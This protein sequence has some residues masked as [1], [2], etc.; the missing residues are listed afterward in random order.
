[1]ATCF[2]VRQLHTPIAAHF[3]S[4]ATQ[5][6]SNEFAHLE[7]LRQFS[8]ELF[9]TN[10]NSPTLGFLLQSAGY[11]VCGP[12]GIGDDGEIDV[13]ECK[14]AFMRQHAHYKQMRPRYFF[15]VHSPKLFPGFADV[16]P[17]GTLAGQDRGGTKA[18]ERMRTNLES[19]YEC[20]FKNDLF[21]VYDLHKPKEGE[22]PRLRETPLVP[23][24]PMA[25]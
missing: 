8:G 19:H 10:V 25:N 4:V 16:L 15:F 20:V 24:I 14:I 17:D 23:Q 2:F 18:V 5:Y 22:T 11:G 1:V 21:L 9:V 7:D 3:R 12:K 6:A 13:N